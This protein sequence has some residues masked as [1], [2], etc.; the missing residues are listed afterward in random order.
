MKYAWIQE[1]AKEFPIV[2][3]CEVLALSSSGYYDWVGREPSATAVR[4]QQITEA[5]K[6]SFGQSHKIYGHRKVHQDVVEDHQIACC[7]ETVRKVMKEQGLESKRRR[8]YVVTTDSNHAYEVAQNVLDR[9]FT[10]EAPNRKW[11]ADITY[12]R[13]LVGWL[14]VAVVIDLFSRKV[15]GWSLSKHIDAALVCQALQAAWVMRRPG[16]DLLHH[17][18]RGSQY[19]SDDFQDLLDRHGVR[20]SMSRKGNCWDNACAE[21]FF[22]SLKNEWICGKVYQDEAEAQKDVFKYIEMFYNRQ[23]RHQSLDYLSPAE[24]ERRYYEALDKDVAA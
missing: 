6:Q 21:S 4:R 10:A 3:M 11:V 14:Y 23:R 7:K 9:E 12:I 20:C 13:T 18:D 2:Q 1:Q 19:A 22:D 5:V 16:A 24:Y 15:V 17:S 8:Q